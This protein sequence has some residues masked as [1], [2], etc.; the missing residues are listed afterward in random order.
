MPTAQE[1]LARLNWL[2]K[3]GQVLPE[4]PCKILLPRIEAKKRAEN[5]PDE[6]GKQKTRLVRELHTPQAYSDFNREFDRYIAAAGD[7]NVAFSIMVRL[8]AQLP[9]ASIKKLA[10][11]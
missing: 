6:Q 7:P 2:L 5:A 3:E 11:E 10:E 4:E 1:E 9:D 8:L